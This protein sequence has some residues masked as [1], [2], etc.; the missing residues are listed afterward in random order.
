MDKDKEIEK[1]NKKIA[2][3]EEKLSLNLPIVYTYIQ[4]ILA[5]LDERG[6]TDQAEFQERLQKA[7]KEL[8]D[9]V[10]NIEFMN[11]MGQI[12]KPENDDPENPK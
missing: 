9:A 4:A 6:I 3:L 2:E 7:R 11:M 10:K 8:T 5:V 12:K 1:L